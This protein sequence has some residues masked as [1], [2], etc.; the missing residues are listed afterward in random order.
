MR[1]QSWGGA[2]IGRY[3]LQGDVGHGVASCPGALP[4]DDGGQAL[5][6]VPTRDPAEGLPGFRAI[7][8]QPLG[9]M[10]LI[11]TRLRVEL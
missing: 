6:E 8:L 10:R 5:L 11:C 4:F 9:F 2:F 7:E 3:L 1:F